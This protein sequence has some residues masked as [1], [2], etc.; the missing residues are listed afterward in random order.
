MGFSKWVQLSAIGGFVGL[1]AGQFPPEP[2]GVTV[3]NSQVEEGVR[4]SYKEV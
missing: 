4:I 2:Q 3:L 1:V